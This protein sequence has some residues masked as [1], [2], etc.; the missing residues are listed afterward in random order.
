MTNIENAD[1]I[2]NKENIANDVNL[3]A[4]NKP[5]NDVFP[6]DFIDF[7][8]KY[9]PYA[10]PTYSIIYIYG[11]NCAVSNKSFTNKEVSGKFELLESDVANAWAY[12][13]QKGLVSVKYSDF[14]TNKSIIEF[15]NMDK[16][17]K[18]AYTF[19]AT[20][21][22]ENNKSNEST[23]QKQTVAI[24]DRPMYSAM[25]IELYRD[26]SDEI[27]DLFVYAQAEFAGKLFDYNELNILFGL[28]DW[29]RLPI[30]VIKYLIEYCSLNDHK[31]LRYIEKVGINWSENGIQTVE[32]AKAHLNLYN[33]DYRAILKACGTIGR[34]PTPSEIKYMDKW[35]KEYQMPLELILLACD[36]TVMQVGKQ[37]FTYTDSIIQSWHESNYKTLQEIEKAE[38]NFNEKNKGTKKPA[39]VKKSKPKNFKERELNTTELEELERIHIEK[40][41]KGN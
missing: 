38:V 19:E 30:Q 41:L 16:S 23:A 18:P 6:P 28:Y 17:F 29:L 22:N 14:E 12:W 9:M 36:K 15:I 37:R 39:T 34:N 27:Q 3:D 5:E 8:S 1:D 4:D 7:L 31:D 32:D 21:S 26:G 13:E 25:E 35:L 40:M 11:Y 20:E 2:T 33:V 10:N 24:L